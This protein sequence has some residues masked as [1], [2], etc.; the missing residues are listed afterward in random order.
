MCYTLVLKMGEHSHKRGL[1]C[2]VHRGDACHLTQ[3]VTRFVWQL[4]GYQSLAHPSSKY[5]VNCVKDPDISEQ[6]HSTM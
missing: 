1:V 4:L 5:V 3:M 2:V 6:D